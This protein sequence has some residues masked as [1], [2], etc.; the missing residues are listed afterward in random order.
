LLLLL[1]KAGMGGMAGRPGIVG[2]AGMAGRSGMV[3]VVAVVVA[4]VVRGSAKSDIA[5]IGALPPCPALIDVGC[6]PRLEC[7]T[8]RL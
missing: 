1:G 4:A 3:V 6:V 8:A 5:I 2:I 7:G